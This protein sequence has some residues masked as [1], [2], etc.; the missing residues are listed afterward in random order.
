MSTVRSPNLPEHPAAHTSPS[1]VNR[2][3]YMDL[4]HRNSVLP[5]L[6][7]SL[8][9][10]RLLGP[11]A[12]TRRKREMVPPEKKDAAYMSK[13]LKNNEAA[14]RSRE[15]RRLKE[16]LL[17]GQLL[18]LSDENAR[19]RDQVLRVQYLSMCAGKVEEAPGRDLCPVYSPA[20]SKSLVWE[21]NWRTPHRS[22]PP[23]SWNQGFDSPFQSSGLIPFSGPR[24]P[25]AVAGTERTKADADA[26][27]QVGF[28]GLI[29][30]DAA[31][32]QAFLPRPDA[33]HPAPML[34]H[35]P[36][37][38]LVPG[39]AVSSNYVLPW[40]SPYLASTAL[41]Q[42]LPLCMQE[43]QGQGLE[44]DAQVALKGRFNGARA[45]HF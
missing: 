40:L 19:L 14:K 15:K 3:E 20:V 6:R 28:S 37:T 12:A 32:L 29:K 39:P 42:S 30:A 34:P 23:F 17:G 43:M 26:S 16:L 7:P 10:Q 4:G 8:Q 13:R 24:I 35:A 45:P 22:I 33:L 2:R 41:H 11:H 18:A 31:S 21:E 38:W 25:S 36:P 9:A 44:E 5:V 27:R 1:P